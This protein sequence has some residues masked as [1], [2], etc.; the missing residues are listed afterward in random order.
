MK[1]MEILI[2]EEGNRVVFERKQADSKGTFW[3]CHTYNFTF[4]V[5]AGDNPHTEMLYQLAKDG[6]YP[7]GAYRWA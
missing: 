3:L 7:R 4:D 6:I 2:D 1:K 5:K